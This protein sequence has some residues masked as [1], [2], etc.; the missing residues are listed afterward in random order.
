MESKFCANCGKPLEEG[1]S[2][3]ENCGIAA[4]NQQSS[5]QQEQ[6]RFQQPV[7]NQQTSYQQP[8][9]QQSNY[10]QQ[11]G[12]SDRES[13]MSVGQY[14]GTFLLGA[15]PLAG[16]ILYIVWAFSSDT[17]INKKN[18]C[19]AWLIMYLIGIALYII[20]IVIIFGALASTGNMY[21]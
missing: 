9:Y 8:S 7:Y 12:V 15:I 16:F 14:V 2:I 21:R 19:R 20:F 1:Q 6:Q 17:N 13:P 5:K 3:C 18:F 10:Q 4:E 11:Y